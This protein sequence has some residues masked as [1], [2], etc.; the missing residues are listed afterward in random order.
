MPRKPNFK[1]RPTTPDSKFNSVDVALFINRMMTC[2]KKSLAER[3]FYSALDIIE[4]KIKDKPSVDVFRKAVENV[5]PVVKVKARRIGGA[6]Y[7]VPEPVDKLKGS[8]IAHRWIIQSA[9]KRSAKTFIQN[10]ANELLEAF[11]NKG[12]AIE[13]KE[14]THKMA[15]ANKAFAHYAKSM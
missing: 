8:A 6:T 1:K 14:H 3:L 12:K 13:L 10:L 15:E 2:G 11:E 5:T 9:R 4:T 7:Q